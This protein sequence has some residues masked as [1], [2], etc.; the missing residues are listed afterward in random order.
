MICRL[1]VVLVILSWPSHLAANTWDIRSDRSGDA[2]TIK[3]GIDSAAAGDTILV[4]PGTYVGSG[5]RDLDFDGKD[6][7]LLGK[8]GQEQTI[9]DL[10][11]L[12]SG[13]VFWRGET[14]AAIVDGFTFFRGTSGA[15]SC[16]AGS[17]TIRNCTFRQN[18]ATVGGAIRVSQSS[19]QIQ[20]CLFVENL[21]TDGGG[22][23][24]QH[25]AM[26]SLSDCVF[27]GN[28]ATSGGGMAISA[29][30]LRVINCAF[31]SNS[32]TSG[33]GIFVVDLR[34]ELSIIGCTFQGN[35][36]TVG[37]GILISSSKHAYVSNCTVYMNTARS[38]GMGAGIMVQ[39]GPFTM[40]NSIVAFNLGMG[41]GC[42]T[43]DPELSC[44]N[45][46]GNAAG[47]WQ[48]CIADQEG[49]FENISEDPL[50][51]NGP[52][53]NLHLAAASPCAPE[54]S[55]ECGLIGAYGV[56]CDVIPVVP[57]T[58]GRIKTLYR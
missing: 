13:I 9:I 31:V 21:A 48:G 47:D 29:S 57:T 3:A 33:G 4:W 40:H 38:R 55:G 14:N 12:G 28:S 15:I 45:I 19:P 58:W 42:E 44:T 30:S 18:Q 22:V 46:Y 43:A 50:F 37:G 27:V 25:S 6:L 16:T 1:I 36:S 10:Q 41:V 39:S 51:C 17:P 5:N 11:E 49:Q 26:D 20:R 56:A 34:T 8:A 23:S 52:T 7:V 54:N 35:D 53:G 32:A 24:L 2:P